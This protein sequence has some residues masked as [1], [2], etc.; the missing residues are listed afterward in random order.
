MESKKN[1]RHQLLYHK[2]QLEA[3]KLECFLEVVQKFIMKTRSLK[4]AWERSVSST[5]IIK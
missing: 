4:V 2:S 5:Q 1:H 3:E